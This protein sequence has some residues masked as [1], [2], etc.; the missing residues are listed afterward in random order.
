MAPKRTVAYLL[1]CSLLAVPVSAAS[2]SP[3][4]ITYNEALA[5]LSSSDLNQRILG[6]EALGTSGDGRAGRYLVELL[7][8]PDTDGI[9]KIQAAYALGILGD[10]RVIDDLIRALEQD[11]K[12][13]TGLWSGIIPTLGEL[14]SETAVPA[15]LLALSN[16]DEHWMGRN[17][18]AVALGKIGSVEAVPTLLQAAWMTDTR[19]AAI[20]AL[21]A[22]GDSR[23]IPIFLNALQDEE[24]PET[25]E[26]AIRGL[27][28]LGNQA[29]PEMIMAFVPYS[30][31]FK[32]TAKRI[33]ICRLLGESG[34]QQAVTTLRQAVIQDTDEQVQACAKEQFN[35]SE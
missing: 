5:L 32:E 4:T 26:Q 31:E 30:A 27:R 21:A 34:N 35:K 10:Q 9:L 17:M 2:D 8:A 22:I 18:A 24:D 6:T 3:H 16:R 14:G 1:Y 20:G 7:E 13:R 15:L 23:A 11:Y 12:N 28:Q 33:R 19:E 29:V 25:V